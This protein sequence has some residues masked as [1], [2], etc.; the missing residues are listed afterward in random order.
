MEAAGGGSGLDLADKWADLDRALRE[1]GTEGN[2]G[3]IY[4]NRAY[5]FLLKIMGAVF[6]LCIRPEAGV[7]S[8]REEVTPL[9]CAVFEIPIAHIAK[10]RSL[11]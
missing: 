6:S 10:E 8:C 9:W 11:C 2:G 5:G 7:K 4:L 1:A 3:D